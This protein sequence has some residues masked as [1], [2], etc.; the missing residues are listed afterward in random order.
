M[1]G[2]KALYTSYIKITLSYVHHRAYFFPM[3]NK[4]SVDSVGFEPGTFS[5]E[6]C[7]LNDPR[8][9]GLLFR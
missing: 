6:T 3:N 2:S 9:R 7:V 1:Y 8:Y 5:I 4:K